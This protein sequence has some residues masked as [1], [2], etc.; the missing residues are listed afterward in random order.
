[1][2]LLFTNNP[3][4][5]MLPHLLISTPNNSVNPKFPLDFSVDPFLKYFPFLNNNLHFKN[6]MLNCSLMLLSEG[7]LRVGYRYPIGK[8]THNEIMEVVVAVEV[9]VIW[10]RGKL[11]YIQLRMPVMGS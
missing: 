9:A 6:T 8:Y 2:M 5:L 7:W 3:Q 11:L 10:V 4:T 1:M